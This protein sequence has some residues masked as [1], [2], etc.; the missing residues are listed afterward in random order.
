MLYSAIPTKVYKAFSDKVCTTIL[1]ECTVPLQFRHYQ[2]SRS[3]YLSL[4]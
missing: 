2:D 1:P 4:P 3:L